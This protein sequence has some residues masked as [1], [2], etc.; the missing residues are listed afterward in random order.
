MTWGVNNPDAISCEGCRLIFTDS[1]QAVY[2]ANSAKAAAA[3]PISQ[4]EWLRSDHTKRPPRFMK[5]GGL[6]VFFLHALYS[7]GAIA[8][9][10]NCLLNLGEFGTLPGP[11]ALRL[12]RA[13]AGTFK[14]W[15]LGMEV[16]L[17]AEKIVV[18]PAFRF[19]AQG[20]SLL[21]ATGTGEETPP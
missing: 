10:G 8:G 21:P 9:P 11:G 2:F 1:F 16:G 14:T 5:S 15:N 6:F 17:I 12:N 19:R 13:A 18:I 3:G 20:V 4:P 7:G